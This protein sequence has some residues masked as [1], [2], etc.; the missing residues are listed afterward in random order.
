[1]PARR[2]F[3][4]GVSL[5]ELT[6]VV[7]RDN[8]RTLGG[9]LAAMELIRRTGVKR[10]WFDDADHGVLVAASRLTPGTNV[11]AYCAG[12]GWRLN[13]LAGA[14]AAVLAA[15]VPS[16]VIVAV[17]TAA[18]FEIDHYRA[19]RMLLAV[20]TIAAAALVLSSTWP[21]VRPHL[22]AGTR[23]WAALIIVIAIATLLLGATPVQTLLVAAVA[24]AL[25][26]KR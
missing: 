11:L 26:T 18:L 23:L 10:G 2:S 6:W 15:S 14:V 5:R 1:V 13:G 17:V 21:L 24:G 3:S 22:K 9:G 8:L 25:V 16:A 12:L 4:G 20:G 19:V 7:L